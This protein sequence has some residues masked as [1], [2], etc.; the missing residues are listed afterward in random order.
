MRMDDP[1]IAVMQ[2]RMLILKSMPQS[3]H[4]AR[5]I[6]ALE[7]TIMILR[8]GSPASKPK[9]GASAATRKKAELETIMAEDDTPDEPAAPSRRVE[10]LG[11][12]RRVIIRT[13]RK[14][15]QVPEDEDAQL[16]RE[17]KKRMGDIMQMVGLTH[18]GMN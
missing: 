6:V 11:E 18:R 9:R 3:A 16:E 12:K 4:G 14:S 17:K 5:E 7:R 13:P 15:E 1:R 10:R 2:K 8:Q